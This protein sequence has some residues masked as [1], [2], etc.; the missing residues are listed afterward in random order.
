MGNQGNG[1]DTMQL[2]H[3]IDWFKWL[4]RHQGVVL[5]GVVALGILVLGNSRTIVEAERDMTGEEVPLFI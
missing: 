1:K 2:E 5:L 4:N 3:R